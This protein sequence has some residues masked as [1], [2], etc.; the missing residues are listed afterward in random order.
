MNETADNPVICAVEPNSECQLVIQAANAVAQ[1]RQCGLT[2]IHVVKPLW[3][4]YVDVNFT[5]LFEAQLATENELVEEARQKLQSLTDDLVDI[6]NRAVSL[7]VKKGDPVTLISEL[8]EAHAEPIIVMGVHN[9]HGLKRLLGSTA[10]GVLNHTTCPMVLVNPHNSRRKA[11]QNVL[12]AVDT[13][14][15]MDTVLN[16]ARP[17]IGGAE[18]T[19]VLTMVPSLAATLGNLQASVFA[20]SWPIADLQENMRQATETTLG[21]AATAAGLE[22]SNT[23][24]L[25]GDPAHNICQAASDRD[26]DLIIMGAGRRN[27]VDRLLIGST[28]HGV[29]NSTPCDVYIAR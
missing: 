25:E 13:A 2:L 18:H 20:S 15:E 7:L 6:E 27:V 16:H 17:Y 3:Q 28:A 5:P 4:P 26:T 9:R 14:C 22:R 29:L 19:L 23:Q 1:Q 10:H 24:V 21:Q 8:A 11:Y 12:V